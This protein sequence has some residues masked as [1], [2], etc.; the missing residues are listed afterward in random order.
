[1]IAIMGFR[2]CRYGPR[3][4]SLFGGSHGAGVP[5]PKPDPAPY[6]PA[7]GRLSS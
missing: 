7:P 2:T 3:T 1:M 6:S 5:S 4:T